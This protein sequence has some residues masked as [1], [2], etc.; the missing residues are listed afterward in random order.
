LQNGFNKMVVGL[1]ERVRL[2][3]L[4]GRHVGHAV[5]QRALAS[6]PRLGGETRTVAVLFIDLVGTTA[7]AE[8]ESAEAVV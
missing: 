5:A 1:D 7:R 4:F 3:S 2:R 6:A 8:R